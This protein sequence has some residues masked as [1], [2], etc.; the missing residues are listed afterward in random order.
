MKK[1]IVDLLEDT[2]IDELKT[3][4]NDKKIRILNEDDIKVMTEKREKIWKEL[5]AYT[6][7][8][9]VKQIKEGN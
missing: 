4:E 5:E 6:Y 2:A 8:N 9:I 7:D 1:L 3:M